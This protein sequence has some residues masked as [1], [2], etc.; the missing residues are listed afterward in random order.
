MKSTEVREKPENPVLN[1][2]FNIALPVFVLNQLTKRLG[3]DGPLIALIVAILIPIGYGI[4][5][6]IV[7]KK[8][9]AIS[10]LGI[11]NVAFT[12]GFALLKLDGWWFAIKEAAF[13]LLIGIAVYISVIWN[14][15]FLKM[16][17][18]NEN[19]FRVQAIEARLQE[20]Q[21]EGQLQG[22][23][24]R[25]TSL[26]AFSFFLSA[27]LNFVLA[28]RIFTEIDKTLSEA[29]QSD[30]LN[31]QIAKMTWQGYVVIAL[32]MMVFMGFVLWYLMSRLTKMTGLKLEEL[33]PDRS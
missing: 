27:I 7:R 13:P 10:I 3:P 11:V 32:P 5:D 16:L 19:V 9:N 14:K 21:T 26:F 18:W 28:A 4:Y 33:L 24:R 22:L 15:P 20:R 12:G 6:Y 2:L 1:L 29:A 31:Q 23:F 30:L 25:A 8:N 17:F